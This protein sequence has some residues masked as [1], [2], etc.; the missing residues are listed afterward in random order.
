MK[1][2][3]FLTFALLFSAAYA[4]EIDDST[5]ESLFKA[6]MHIE[7]PPTGNCYLTTRSQEALV[8]FNGFDMLPSAV[9]PYR[10]K[11]KEKTEIDKRGTSIL[12]KQIAERLFR[13]GRIDEGIALLK[14]M[15]PP[16]NP[17]QGM[18]CTGYV[19]EALLEQK[20]FKEAWDIA[21]SGTLFERAGYTRDYGNIGWYIHRTIA[22]NHYEKEL[23]RWDKPSPYLPPNVSPEI[24]NLPPYFPNK[25]DAEIYRAE[26]NRAMEFLLKLPEQLTAGIDPRD[27][28]K[29]ENE[30]SNRLKRY[31]IPYAFAVLGRGDEALAY[32]RSSS[33]NEANERF[34][35]EIIERKRP[36]T[37]TQKESEQRI[38]AEL[39]QSEIDQWLENPNSDKAFPSLRRIADAGRAALEKLDEIGFYAHKN[40]TPQEAEKIE[41]AAIAIF[42]DNEKYADYYLV[43]YY[44]NMAVRLM[45]DG[46]KEKGKLYVEK[47]VAQ[48]K[49]THLRKV[50]EILI[51]GGYVDEAE[52]LVAQINDRLS[53][54]L[55]MLIA[56]K[57]IAAGEKEKAKAALKIAIELPVLLNPGGS[58]YPVYAKRAT[59]AA[60]CDDKELFI[61]I[62][63]K[64][65]K[66]VEK[67]NFGG[68]G[69]GPNEAL[70]VFVRQLAAYGDKD[71]PLFG[72]TEEIADEFANVPNQR[73]RRAELYYALGVSRAM[74]GDHVAARRLLKQ[75]LEAQQKDTGG[76]TTWGFCSA[77]V[78]A[79]SYAK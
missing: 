47:A 5:Y 13:E 63:D 57:R 78:E 28:V 53:S 76:D 14:K 18:L 43:E 49:E 22:K 73:N 75:G 16:E 20:R 30:C 21:N 74:L 27:S 19:S 33:N 77:I 58:M 2:L 79:R 34:V 35:V 25:D 40:K 51:T 32:M 10:E 3:A 56:E 37:D 60:Q 72:Q 29:L 17:S 52:P 26:A 45:K 41:T 24:P 71:H 70:K 31:I 15:L 61:K 50:C 6:A 69:N 39:I 42:K 55:H 44:A 1:R 66:E 46:E 7:A 59:L 38:K 4:D 36:V 12:T 23:P 8:K 62:M 65:M 48:A 67:D 9:E 68:R 11:E 54:G 64:C